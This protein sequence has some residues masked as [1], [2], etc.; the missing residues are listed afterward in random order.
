[1]SVLAQSEGS[2]ILKVLGQSRGVINYLS[3]VPDATGLSPEAINRFLD[4]VAES[5]KAGE[6]TNL[7]QKHFQ[8]EEAYAHVFEDESARVAFTQSIT[9]LDSGF[10]L[11][12]VGAG[13][14][15]TSA[16]RIIKEY[17]RNLFDLIRC[18]EKREKNVEILKEAWGRVREDGGTGRGRE[19]DE[20][21]LDSAAL[22]T[23][24]HLDLSTL[25]KALGDL[26]KVT[27]TRMA[28]LEDRLTS[29]VDRFGL[30]QSLTQ[31]DKNASH[32]TRSQ[33]L[34][35]LEEKQ[36]QEEAHVYVA[37]YLYHLALHS[38][39]SLCES[40]QLTGNT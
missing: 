12:G 4:I 8:L 17:K 21:D 14:P 39:P 7:L 32:K 33:M 31:G 18:L 3:F 27:T 23:S 16:S 25:T 22:P 28:R 2:R 30:D 40:R 26:M 34:L 19:E 5:D 15:V 36:K 11:S 9:S 24:F 29:S 13:N 37:H 35:H 1:M 38:Y 10:S 20:D 6:L